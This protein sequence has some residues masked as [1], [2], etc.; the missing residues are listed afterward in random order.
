MH[1][2]DE[3][4]IYPEALQAVSRVNRSGVLAVV[5][6]NQSAVARGLLSE[7][8]L[9]KIHHL[10]NLEFQRNSAHIDAFYYCPH[11][12][13]AGSGPYTQVCSCR[14][15]EPGML[16]RAAR[17]LDIEL[18]ES[19]MFG[20]RLNDVETGNRAGCQSI[21]VKTGYGSEE[22]AGNKEKVSPLRRPAYVAENILEGVEWIL[23]RRLERRLE[24]H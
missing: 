4:K 1:R 2:F 22:M 15:P 13:E 21:L 17:E 12:P 18:K 9:Q 3:V 23:E 10:I 5:I 16:L 6:T 14:K 8:D 11:H 7:R 20:D 24:S 19:Y